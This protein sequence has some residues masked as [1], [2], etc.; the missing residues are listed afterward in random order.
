[1]NGD[2]IPW[3]QSKIL[4]GL[5]VAVV[6]QGLAHS[7]LAGVITTDQGVQIINWILEGVSGLA[8]GYAAHARITSPVPPIAGTKTAKAATDGAT[9]APLAKPPEDKQ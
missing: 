6:T 4:Q 8:A 7:G 5:L 1:M 3:W 2:P 9:A